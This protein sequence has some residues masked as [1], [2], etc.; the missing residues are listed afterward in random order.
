[1]YE[2]KGQAE[3]YVRNLPA[4]EVNPPF[5]VVV[6]VGHSIDDDLNAAVFDADGW[7][8]SLSDDEIL[9]RLVELNHERAAVQHHDLIF[10]K[11]VN[12]D[13][14]WWTIKIEGDTLVPFESITFRSIIRDGEFS[15]FIQRMRDATVEQCRKLEY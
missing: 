14:E 7:P 6:D 13:D 12:G 3:L 5:L 4:S 11:Q 8:H 2:A 15:S 10:V 9:Q 1:M